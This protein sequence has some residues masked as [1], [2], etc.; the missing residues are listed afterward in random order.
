MAT[1]RSTLRQRLPSPALGWAWL[2][3]SVLIG[4]T[5]LYLGLAAAAEGNGLGA[6]LV[7]LTAIQLPGAAGGWGVVRGREWG[8]S[9]L[10]GASLLNIIVIPVG[11]LLSGYTLWA[12][13]RT[14]PRARDKRPPSDIPPQA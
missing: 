2:V 14:P 3:Y 9:G 11:P 6:Q 4:L 13:L 10:I 1:Q 5:A 8:R 12:L 7:L